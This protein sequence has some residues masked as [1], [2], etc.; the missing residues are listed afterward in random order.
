MKTASSRS[1]RRRVGL[2]AGALIRQAHVARREDV[3]VE[4]SK[5]VL[6]VAQ[7]PTR[8]DPAAFP[9]NCPRQGKAALKALVAA[10]FEIASY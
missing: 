5:C 8:S 2:P 10:S 3:L 9:T 6:E 7:S 1:R 4:R